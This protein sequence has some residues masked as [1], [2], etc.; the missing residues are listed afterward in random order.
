MKDKIKKKQQNHSHV[1]WNM[2]HYENIVSEF[3][4]IYNRCFY[5]NLSRI[6]I[7]YLN[8]SIPISCYMDAESM[9]YVIDE[10]NIDTH[11]TLDIII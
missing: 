3:D 11:S 8:Y 7:V 6:S 1:P 2:I 5:V 9:G 10:N 4:Y